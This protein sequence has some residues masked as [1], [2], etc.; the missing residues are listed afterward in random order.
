MWVTVTD[1]N[2]LLQI[3]G[4]NNT[5]FVCMFA[6]KFEIR[7]L[8]IYFHSKSWKMMP[9]DGKGNTKVISIK[10]EN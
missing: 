8:L 1:L 2:C 4:Q 7:K 3:V 10:I 9:D 6:I 5:V